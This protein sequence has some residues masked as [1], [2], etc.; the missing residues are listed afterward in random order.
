MSAKETARVKR[1]PAAPKAKSKAIPP[2]STPSKTKSK[3]EIPIRKRKVEDGDVDNE[4]SDTSVSTDEKYPTQHTLINMN[5]VYMLTDEKLE[6]QGPTA[7]RAFH[8]QTHLPNFSTD[9]R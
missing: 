6:E 1:N 4:Q 5:E 3:E 9:K 2:T 8:N 7:I